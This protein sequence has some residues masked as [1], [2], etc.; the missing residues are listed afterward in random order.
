MSGANIEPLADDDP[1]R[2]GTYRLLGRIASGGMGRIYLGRAAAGGGLVAVKT[3]LAEGDVSAIDR[4]RFARE[5]KVARRVRGD[6]TARVLAADPDAE[7]PWMATE[8]IPAP[9]LAELVQRAGT[10]SGAAVR[11]VARGTV[12][13]L[14]GLHAAGIVHRDVKPQNLLLPASGPCLIDFGIS[15]AQDL[16]RTSL[17]LGTIAFTSPE[18]ARGE[19]ST[20]ASDVYS[21]GATLF[22]LA[23]GRAPY[24]DGEETLRLLTRVSEADVELDGL[25]AELAAVVVPCLALAPDDRP[26]SAEV[27]AEVTV[28]L[29]EAPTSTDAAGWLPQP[30]A[31]LIETYARA[32]HELAAGSTCVREIVD[33]DTGIG[34]PPGHTPTRTFDDRHD[35]EEPETVDESIEDGDENLWD[36]WDEAFWNDPA[37]PTSR[38]VPAMSVRPSGRKSR[39]FVRT[40]QAL[41]AGILV[42]IAVVLVLAYLEGRKMKELDSIDRAFLDLSV[43]D[44]LG[45][46]PMEGGWATRAPEIVDCGRADAYVRVVAVGGPRSTCSPLGGAGDQW[47]HYLP[48]QTSVTVCTRRLFRVGQC[49]VGKRDVDGELNAVVTGAWDCRSRQLPEGYTELLKITAYP[50]TSSECRRDAQDTGEYLRYT[51]GPEE[52]LCLLRL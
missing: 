31:E 9:S 39:V 1:V 49:T 51:V 37:E 52:T 40:V 50:L 43:G 4:R 46:T 15:H 27:L 26:T 47:R 30:W 42:A 7:R 18:Q 22:H 33:R 28:D 10:L 12:Q 3:L 2:L 38:D 5:V 8:Y 45:S 19:R 24:P 20:V 48:E 14:V 17:T 35:G 32:G 13:A 21:L 36:E 44:C 16:T 29:A 11:W 25:P 23:V 34:A 6:H 41:M